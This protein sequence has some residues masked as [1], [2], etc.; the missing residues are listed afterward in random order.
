MYR[1]HI[2]RIL[3]TLVCLQSAKMLSACI[4]LQL[5]IHA[6]RRMLSPQPQIVH[7]HRHGSISATS[8]TFLQQHAASMSVG[9]SSCLIFEVRERLHHTRPSLQQVRDGDHRGAHVRV[10][11]EQSLPAGLAFAVLHACFIEASLEGRQ[12][13]HTLQARR[14]SQWCC[15]GELRLRIELQDMYQADVPVLAAML[16]SP[17]HSVSHETLHDLL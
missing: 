8:T 6:S 14:L 5:M 13:G 1:L 12:L 10:P 11:E 7:A 9:S 2:V 16:W 3:T 4:L 17:L 15:K